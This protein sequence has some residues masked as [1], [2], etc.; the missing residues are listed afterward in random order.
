MC[1]DLVKKRRKTLT[2]LNSWLASWLNFTEIQTCQA[3]HPEKEL[4]EDEALFHDMVSAQVKQI[5]KNFE[6]KLDLV[7]KER[8]AAISIIESCVKHVFERPN[9]RSY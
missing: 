8:E 6:Y 2:S 9:N 5:V 1:W 7:R 3:K 4:T